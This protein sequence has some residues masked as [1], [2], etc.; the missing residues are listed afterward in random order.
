MNNMLSDRHLRHQAH[1]W[2]FSACIHL[3]VLGG[4][5]LLVTELEHPALPQPIRLDIALVT[6]TSQVVTAPSTTA[7]PIPAHSPPVSTTSEHSI[8]RRL[9]PKR[10]V[11]P[12]EVASVTRHIQTTHSQLVRREVVPQLTTRTQD[13]RGR[14]EEVIQTK[15]ETHTTEEQQVVMET[16]P[17]IAQSIEPIAPMPNNQT[18]IERE[19]TVETERRQAT[20][21]MVEHVSAIQQPDVLLESATSMSHESGIEHRPVMERAVQTMADTHADYGWLAESLWQRIEE[22]KHY[23]MQARK[24]RWEGRVILEAVI[25]DDGTIMDLRIEESSGHAI[26]DQDALAVVKKASPLTLKHPLGQPHITILVPIN[27]SLKT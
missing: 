16:Q 23:P 19:P 10:V 24:R 15:P 1:G 17:S 5:F 7:S 6:P 26:L 14:E 12:H 4:A 9:L 2:T 3:C 21:R 27:Y 18:V 11:S 13:I 20:E 8:E 22:L 25:R